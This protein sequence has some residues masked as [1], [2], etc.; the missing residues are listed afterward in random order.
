MSEL[1]LAWA[2][3]RSHHVD[4]PPSLQ[5]AQVTVVYGERDLQTTFMIPYNTSINS[6]K[7][8]A[9]CEICELLEKQEVK[10]VPCISID[11]S[12]TDVYPAPPSRLSTAVSLGSN[13]MM[14]VWPAEDP[15]TRLM[16]S[17][18]VDAFTGTT[19]ELKKL[20][21]R[22]AAKSLVNESITSQVEKKKHGKQNKAKQ[23]NPSTGD[24]LAKQPM[25]GGSSLEAIMLWLSAVEMKIVDQGH[26]ISHDMKIASLDT[27]IIGL[28]KENADLS[29]SHFSPLVSHFLNRIV[30]VKAAMDFLV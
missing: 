1:K 10:G 29:L 26:K 21:A 17:P 9:I 28:K 23:Q 11:P 8:T 24:D 25:D 15:S 20:H 22:K 3:F 16:P 30:L 6:A 13:I 5:T 14:F 18:L 12:W 2:A 27:E 7:Q 19:S 4:M